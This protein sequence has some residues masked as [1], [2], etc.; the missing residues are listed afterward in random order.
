MKQNKDKKNITVNIK[1]WFPSKI[2][3][4]LLLYYRRAKFIVVTVM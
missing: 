2:I 4:L 3:T 1:E